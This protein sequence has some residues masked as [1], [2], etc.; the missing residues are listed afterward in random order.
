VSSLKHQ[1]LVVNTLLTIWS[2]LVTIARATGH[3]SP[4]GVRTQGFGTRRRSYRRAAA[5]RRD[6]GCPERA[7]AFR[8]RREVP[9]AG[10][11]AAYV[12][13]ARALGASDAEIVKAVLPDP[14]G[15]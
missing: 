15:R 5:G 1:Q 13:K 12:L 10:L 7:Q 8:G 9:A 2:S 14:D 11:A 4:R 3:R 6:Q